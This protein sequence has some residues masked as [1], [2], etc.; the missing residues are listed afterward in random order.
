M[1]AQAIFSRAPKSTALPHQIRRSRA[2]QKNVRFREQVFDHSKTHLD[3]LYVYPFLPSAKSK[4]RFPSRRKPNT[5][6]LLATCQ[7]T[8]ER[9]GLVEVR[10]CRCS[11]YNMSIRVKRTLSSGLLQL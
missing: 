4:H 10:G 8:S 11:A 1:S 5:L 7:F 2:S 3:L 6:A 9:F